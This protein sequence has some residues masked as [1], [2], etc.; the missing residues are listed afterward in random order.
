MILYESHPPCIVITLN[1][2]DRRNAL[3]RGLIAELTAAFA[4]GLA[5]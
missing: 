5:Q 2:A 3:S 1:R 4:G